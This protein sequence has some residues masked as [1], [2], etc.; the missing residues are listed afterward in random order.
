MELIKIAGLYKSYS[1]K[2]KTVEVL[3]GIDLSVLKG[4]MVAVVGASGVG[5]STLLHLMGA[6]DRPTQGD[7]FYKGERVFGQTDKKLAVFRNKNIG[8]VFQFHH[9]LP[10]FTALENVMMPLLIGGEDMALAGKMAEKLLCDVGLQER[11]NH[12][13]GE[14]SGGEQQR[15]AI[16]RALI[17][18]PNVLLADEPTGNLDT[19]TG[20]DVFNLLLR[21]NEEK[22]IT[23]IVVTHNERLAGKMKRIISMVDGKIYEDAVHREGRG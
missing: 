8:F 6:L 3:K 5:K 16:A 21:F 14:L 22:G 2:L 1:N 23:M 9:L 12:K 19:Y 18:S 13:P 7:V 4:E 17:Q 15:V 20:D 10:E 11:L